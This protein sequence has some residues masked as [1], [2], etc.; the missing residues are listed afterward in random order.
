[1]IDKT[2]SKFIIV[3]IINTIVG[4]SIMYILYNVAHTSYWFSSFMNYFIGSIVSFFLNKY[5]TFNNKSKSIKQIIL[6]SLNILFCYLIAYGIAK[7]LINFI[8]SDYSITT[9]ENIA[10]A[11]GMVL[12]TLLN[13]F[14]QR[15]IVFRKNTP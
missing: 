9:R 3:G 1:M 5:F 2:F 15:Y 14:I 8:L 4:T 11:A 6:F 10:M 12:F 13:Y 7:K